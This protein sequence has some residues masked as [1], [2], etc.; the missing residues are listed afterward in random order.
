MLANELCTRQKRFFTSCIP[1]MYCL[2]ETE[3]A[4][5]DDDASI[6][7]SMVVRTVSTWWHS[8][9]HC[10]RCCWCVAVAI[11]VCDKLQFRSNTTTN[12]LIR[13]E[14]EHIIDREHKSRTHNSS[15]GMTGRILGIL[16]WRPRAATC[17]QRVL[18][19]KY[20]RQT[21]NVHR[22]F[23]TTSNPVRWPAA[24]HSKIFENCVFRCGWNAGVP[25]GWLFFVGVCM[26]V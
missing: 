12:Q 24:C 21:H 26:C 9:C 10:R 17:C 19:A 16:V 13:T 1:I 8:G 25:G 20:A 23:V 6:P 18:C 3:T 22:V 15:H 11:S 14:L 2:Y 4:T 7:C 5:L